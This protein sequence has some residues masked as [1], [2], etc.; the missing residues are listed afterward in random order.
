MIFEK[1][2]LLSVSPAFRDHKTVGRVLHVRVNQIIRKSVPIV[3]RVMKD[4]S[5]L[6]LANIAADVQVCSVY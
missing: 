6:A 1:I 3:R 2:S 4:T 5:T